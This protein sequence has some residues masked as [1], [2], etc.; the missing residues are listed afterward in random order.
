MS[1]LLVDDNA[2]IRQGLSQKLQSLGCA[3]VEVADGLRALMLARAQSFRA[4]VLDQR[5]PLMDGLRLARNLRALP[6]CEA[7]PLILLTTDKLE[8]IKPLAQRAGI[9]TVLAKPVEGRELARALHSALG[10]AVDHIAA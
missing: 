3:V 9:T 6:G 10:Q 5:M 7:I 4:V 2:A 1:I 8:T